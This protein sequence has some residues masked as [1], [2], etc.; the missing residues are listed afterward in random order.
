MVSIFTNDGRYHGFAADRLAAK[1]VKICLEKPDEC[2]VL[3]E[4]ETATV[5]AAGSLEGRA[6]I[7]KGLGQSVKAI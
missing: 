1:N 2:R 3:N 6:K 5:Q 4:A 7:V